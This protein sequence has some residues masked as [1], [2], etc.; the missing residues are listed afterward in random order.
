MG[1]MT[2]AVAKLGAAV[3]ELKGWGEIRTKLFNACMRGLA[4]VF[5]DDF[6]D[7][8]RGEYEHIMQALSWLPPAGGR[9]EGKIRATLN[10]MTVEE[11]NDLAERIRAIY[12]RASNVLHGGSASPAAAA[13]DDLVEDQEEAASSGPDPKIVGPPMPE[14]KAEELSKAVGKTI[15]AVE[16]GVVEGLPNWVHEG[17]AIVLHFTDGTALSIEIGSNA[18]NLSYEHP[19]LKPEDVHTDLMP[20]WRDRP[21]PE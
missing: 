16:Y 12:S 18:K 17:E 11:A 6:P 1:D 19:G 20:M 7:P 2:Y 14:H 13:E 9:N 4:R 8:L 3:D 15:A 10:A 21:P 5:P